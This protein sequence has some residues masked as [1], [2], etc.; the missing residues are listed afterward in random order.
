MSIGLSDS[1]VAD[2]W[3]HADISIK[4]LLLLMER[5]ESWAVDDDDAV[6]AALEKLALVI[7]TDP[8]RVRQYVENHPDVWLGVL[9]VMRATRSQMLQSILNNSSVSSDELIR[10]AAQRSEHDQLSLL[11]LNRVALIVRGGLFMS[12]YGND[13]YEEVRAA[14]NHVYA[15]HPDLKPHAHSLN[16][17]GKEL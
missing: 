11:Y 12:V 7:N 5:H 1:A 16:P 10:V 13:S 9:G 3:Q 6:Q 8:S 17:T 4:Q 15:A 14:L 2:F